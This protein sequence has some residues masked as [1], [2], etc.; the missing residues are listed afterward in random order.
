MLGIPNPQF[1]R[2]YTHALICVREIRTQFPRQMKTYFTWNKANLPNIHGNDPPP[3]FL[4]HHLPPKKKRN[5]RLNLLAAIA[6][7][8]FF[9]FF[10]GEKT[11]DKKKTNKQE[12]ATLCSVWASCRVS[13]MWVFSCIWLSCCDNLRRCLIFTSITYLWDCSNYNICLNRCIFDSLSGYYIY[14]LHAIQNRLEISSIN[15]I[16]NTLFYTR[17]S[18]S[19]FL[20]NTG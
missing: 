9:F 8:R 11:S 7:S 10:M 16:R 4:N 15:D 13:R 5:P 3:F 12:R 2:T 19:C 1:C 18:I 14:I 6:L 20:M 17:F